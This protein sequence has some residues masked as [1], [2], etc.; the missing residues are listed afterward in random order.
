M[1]A[2]AEGVEFDTIAREWRMKW[3]PDSEKESLVKVQQLI[4]A[5]LDK[6]KAVDGVKNVQR[7]VCGGCL[8]FK[9]IIALD[10]EKFGSW[11]AAEFAPESEFLAAAAE[12]PGITTIET[13]NYTIMP[14]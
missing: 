6:V 3:S 11:E 2:I 8:D 12:I 1:P 9:I 4:S 14:M 13:Q 10:F 5:T 7:I